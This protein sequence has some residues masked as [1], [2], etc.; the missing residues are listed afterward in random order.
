MDKI[1]LHGGTQEKDIV[2]L[3]KKVKALESTTNKLWADIRYRGI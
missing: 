2:S 3:K 1:L